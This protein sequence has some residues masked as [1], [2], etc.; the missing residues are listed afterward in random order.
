MPFSEEQLRILNADFTA[1]TGNPVS[2]FFCP[3]TLRDDLDAVLCDGHI[4]NKSI[5]TAARKTIVQ[6]QD[7]DN[8]YGETIEPDLVAFLNVPEASPQELIAR[9]RS[10]T[11]TMP[12]GEKVS[13][14]FARRKARPKFPR[15]DLLDPA[16][17]QKIVSP[18]LR[19]ERIE[20]KPHKGLQVEWLM[21]FTDSAL[22][23]S[24]LKSLL[25]LV[26]HLGLQVCPHAS[27]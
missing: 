26:S 5:K 25:G 9:G 8:Y 3:I 6:R 27:R 17:G 7:V 4:L 2:R 18:Y 20:P 10:L 12:S 19:N 24:M 21:G 11:V 14:F 22:L 15:I 1:V 13:A 16:T 23:G